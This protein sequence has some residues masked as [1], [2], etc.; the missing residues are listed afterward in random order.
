MSTHQPSALEAAAAAGRADAE[1]LFAEYQRGQAARHEA[2]LALYQEQQ[3]ARRRLAERYGS[4]QE[5]RWVSDPNGPSV[6]PVRLQHAFLHKAGPR[7]LRSPEMEQAP[8]LEREDALAAAHMIGLARHDARRREITVMRQILAHGVTWDELAYA[9][10]TTVDELR[11]WLRRQGEQLDTWPQ[12]GPD[13]HPA[14]ER[15]SG[16]R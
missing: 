1:Q 3:Q 5:K 9:L 12:P 15:G 6:D 14:T 8:E 16:D 4:D 7:H 10:E 11:E 2:R 13:G